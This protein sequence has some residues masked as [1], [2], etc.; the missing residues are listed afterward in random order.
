MQVVNWKDNEYISEFENGVIKVWSNETLIISKEIKGCNSAIYVPE[1][2]IIYCG[3][4]DE[5]GISK[6]IGDIRMKDIEL[7]K[8]VGNNFVLAKKAG[9]N[10]I[11][12]LQ[13]LEVY[14]AP[15]NNVDDIYVKRQRQKI[16]AF[17]IGETVQD[18]SVF[19]EDDDLEYVLARGA[20]L[21][22]KNS[23]E[24][25]YSLSIVE[26]FDSFSER[27]GT[28]SRSS[29]NIEMK[30]PLE[31]F[32]LGYPKL[33]SIGNSGEYILC[34]YKKYHFCIVSNIEGDIVKLFELPSQFDVENVKLYFNNL[35][36]ILTV[37][38]GV[39]HRYYRYWLEESKE[40]T[41][42]INKINDIYRMG[43]SQKRKVID[44][45]DIQK[46]FWSILFEA[47]L[48]KI[49]EIDM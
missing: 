10:V 5:S 40:V 2:G 26:I 36:N 38:D 25:L 27:Y 4:M 47:K 7:L 44:G 20:L 17:A 39:Y 45:A 49:S 35:T 18:I 3:G 31:L 14:S 41:H 32:I 9:K 42:N 1:T 30:F 15:L 21:S 43:L 29:G 12:N 16:E 33:L 11:M 28:M 6:K 48:K 13:S 24:T 23:M 34:Y 19:S 37:L 46:L 8:Y 22:D